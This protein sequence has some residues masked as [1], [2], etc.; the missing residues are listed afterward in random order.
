MIVKELEK[1]KGQR[2]KGSLKTRLKKLKFSGKPKSHT[3]EALTLLIRTCHV[4]MMCVA[5]PLSIKYGM[6]LQEPCM[7]RKLFIF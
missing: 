4:A 2:E 5:L 3:T 6:L 1:V 7:G